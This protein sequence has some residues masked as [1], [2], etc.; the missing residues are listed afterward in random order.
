M[1]RWRFPAALPAAALVLLLLQGSVLAAPATSDAAVAEQA[2]RWLRSGYDR[3]DAALAATGRELGQP[4]SATARRT[5]QRTRALVAARA[6]R[7][8]VAEA[9]LDALAELTR[10]GDRLAL[11]DAHL[12]RAALDEQRDQTQ[13]AAFS[14]QAAADLYASRCGPQ[15]T[16]LPGCDHRTAWLAWTILARLAN[17]AG[18]RTAALAHN[19]AALEV[20]RRSDDAGL[21]ALSLALLVALQVE[22]GDGSAAQRSLMQA[23][24]QN[25][26]PMDPAARLD[27]QARVAMSQSRVQAMRGDAPGALRALQAARRLAQQARS[28]RLEAQ[29]LTNL[30]DLHARAGRPREALA[31]VEAAL[32]TV[33]QHNDQRL[34]RLLL[35]NAA[36][37][38]IGLGRVTDAKRQAERLFEL[39]AAGGSAASQATALREVA[40][41]L[42]AAGDP[43][44]ALDLFHRELELVERLTE[45]QRKATESTLRERYNR[46]AQQRSIELK[47]RDNAVQAAELVNRT[48][49][50]RLW[51]AAA[52]LL[53]LLAVLVGALLR[54]MR[55][56]QRALQHSQAQLRLQSERDP[57]TGLA[58][59]RHG[60][61][62]LRA[63][64]EGAGPGYA[65]ALLLVDV[66]HFKHVNDGHGHG[67]GDQ[68]LV[69]VARRLTHAVRDGDLVVRWGGEEFLVVAPLRVGGTALDELAARLL[70]SVSDTPVITAAPAGAVA[71]TVSIG[72]GA[73]PLD[74]AG[75]CGSL[76][77][78]R[79]LNLA[80][81]ALYTAK[82]QGRNRAVGIAGLQ[83][84]APIDA[85]TLGRVE[86]D[87]EG[88]WQEGLLRLVIQ[89]GL[90]GARS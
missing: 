62:H 42:A 80:D 64:V 41:G 34:E 84:G 17:V 76:S 22:A 18:E 83:A 66:D 45:A 23:Q 38:Q 16:A 46:E 68:V 10:A 48:L 53:G 33:R 81:M 73:F 88:A 61:D 2:D 60:Q 35:H 28:P 19:K 79:A 49:V 21:Q 56:T 4:L 36:L 70:R 20:A 3:P 14:A 26:D 29:V 27:T 58:N 51:A 8:A 24:Q 90:S 85:T 13:A 54:R 67:V 37:A 32:P 71:V 43:R 40:D 59:R 78:E 69:E 25:L 52:V 1:S 87:F 44:G 39:W 75:G 9:A 55:E 89:P 11:A 47:A 15:V 6:G 86:A 74:G 63:G 5:W 65:G 31:M 30:S 50:Q 82:S 77:W 7:A 12:T 72:Y 57:L